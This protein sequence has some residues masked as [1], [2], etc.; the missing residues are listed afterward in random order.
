MAAVGHTLLGT[1]ESSCHIETRIITNPLRAQAACP[2]AIL[3]SGNK[4]PQACLRSLLH[5]PWD[6]ACSSVMLRCSRS[7]QR[8][9]CERLCLRENKQHSNCRSPGHDILLSCGIVG[10]ADGA[11]HEFEELGCLRF[12][13]NS[14]CSAHGVLRLRRT[15]DEW[16]LKPVTCGALRLNGRSMQKAWR[17]SPARMPWI[18]RRIETNGLRL[19]V[20]ARQSGSTNGLGRFAPAIR[21]KPGCGAPWRGSARSKAAFQALWVGSLCSI[22]IHGFC[23]FGVRFCV[24]GQSPLQRCRKAVDRFE[25]QARSWRTTW[26]EED[27][28]PQHTPARPLSQ[29]EGPTF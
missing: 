10:G 6:L 1:G 16:T 24:R 9:L 2:A 29:Y 11:T 8:T 26:E 15:K 17:P 5:C 28:A 27:Q 7:L 18:V 14:P 20:T 4:L 22:W 23:L 3:K 25:E 21:L 13:Q 12:R 19:S